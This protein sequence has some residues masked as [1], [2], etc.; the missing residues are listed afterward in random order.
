MPIE[1]VIFD[2]DGVLV[3]SEVYW[4]KAREDFA[5]HRGL[6]WTMDDQ[7]A[8]MGRN[9]VEW[10]HVMKERLHLNMTLEQIME[11]VIGRVLAQYE[12]KFPALPGAL[13]SVPLAAS[14]YK[15][16]LASGSPIRV[17]DYVMEHTGLNRVFE[18]VVYADNMPNGK[19]APDVYIETMKRLGVTPQQS[20]G[21]EDSSNGVRALHNAGMWIIAAPSPG[22]TLPDE[23][24]RLAHRVIGSME[25]F[26]LELVEGITT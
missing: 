10:A 24:T 11:D 5:E 4:K 25:A 17:I 9:T 12:E 21:I 16:A 3:D 15:V 19:P 2:M 8:A 26:S 13:E 6:I 7:R 14:R 1:A 20:V 23:I 18:A 22:F